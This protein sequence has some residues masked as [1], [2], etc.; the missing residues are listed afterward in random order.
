[1]LKEFFYKLVIIIVIASGGA[2]HSMH[3][4]VWSFITM[5][6]FFIAGVYIM[7]HYAEFKRFH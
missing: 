4:T 3:L 2:I 5:T 6:M 7:D 1:M